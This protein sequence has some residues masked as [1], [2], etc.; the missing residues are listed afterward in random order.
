MGH[1]VRPV[2]YEFGVVREAGLLFSLSLPV[3]LMVAGKNI[4][5][6]L[7]KEHQ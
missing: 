7:L 2:L 4:N 6:P 5:N 3:E 1:P